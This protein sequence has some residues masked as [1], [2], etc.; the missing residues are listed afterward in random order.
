MRKIEGEDGWKAKRGE[1]H[2]IFLGARVGHGHSC[3][4]KVP[5]LRCNV[6]LSQRYPHEHS[7]CPAAVKDFERVPRASRSTEQGDSGSCMEGP[8]ARYSLC[9]ST[10]SNLKES[11]RRGVLGADSSVALAMNPIGCWRS[12]EE[13]PGGAGFSE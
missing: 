8:E 12:L 13:A 4:R 7:F 2:M 9:C 5:Q 6:P 1:Q 3:L 10:N 11:C